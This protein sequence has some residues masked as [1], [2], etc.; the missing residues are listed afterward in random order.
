MIRV[1]I[2]KTQEELKELKTAAVQKN[3]DKVFSISHKMKPAFGYLKI[4]KAE[5]Y[6][7]GIVDNSRNKTKQNNMPKK[8]E[9]LEIEMEKVISVLKQDFKGNL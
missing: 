3:W 6:L 4:D 5:E 8:I 7:L 1:F 2:K 9:L